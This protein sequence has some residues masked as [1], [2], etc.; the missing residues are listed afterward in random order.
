M[1]AA[2]LVDVGRIELRDVPC[3]A[4]APREVLV[5]VTGVG[6]C[7]TDFHIFAGHANYNRDGRGRAIPPRNEAQILGHE[8]A[9]VVEETGGAVE[10][11]GVGD[12]VVVD[13]GR[14]WGRGA[15]WPRW[16]YG[17]SGDWR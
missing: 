11:L 17:A 2:V 8:I 13:R 10:D 1:K 6:L 3:P 4:P 14:N 15:G 7:G 9:G 12:R 5:R 16:G